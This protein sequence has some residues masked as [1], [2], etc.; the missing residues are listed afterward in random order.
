MNVLLFDIDGTLIHTHGAGKDAMLAAVRNEFAPDRMQEDVD[1]LGRSDRGIMRDVFAA[2]GIENTESNWQRFVAAYVPGLKANLP[3]RNGVILP[4]VV[5]LLEQLRQQENVALGLLT[6][7]IEQGARAKLEHFELLNYFQFGAFGDRHF[8]RRGIAREAMDNARLCLDMSIDP[9]RVWV[10]G[11][12]LN[13]IDCARAI[14]A[15]A[16]AV[17]TGMHT[18]SQLAQAEPDVVLDDLSDPGRITDLLN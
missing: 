17:A 16:V 7:N 6:G 11:D 8:D 13:D 5:S 15:N 9:E 3:Q 4:G 10:L 14:G 18:A 1:L 2:H 12:T